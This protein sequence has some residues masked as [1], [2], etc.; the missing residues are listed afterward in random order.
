M[1]GDAVEAGG[2]KMALEGGDHFHGRPV[3]FSAY[4][5][6]IA[7]FGQR[8]L[9]VADAVADDAWLER[10]AAHDRRRLHP[11]ADARISQR[12][13]RRIASTAASGRSDKS[14]EPQSWPRLT[15]STPIEQELM[16]SSPAH[17]ATPACQARL[18]SGTHC[19]MRPSSRTM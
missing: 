14:G 6:A 10:F 8:L 1:I 12:M 19:T 17:D 5:D 7:I 9:H 4:R 11:M 15:I 13:P 3:V 18:A 2:A 16:S